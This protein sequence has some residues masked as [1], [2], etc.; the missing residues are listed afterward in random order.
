MSA[1]ANKDAVK[2]GEE[3]KIQG[4]I[5]AEREAAEAAA[6]E[7]LAQIKAVNEAL[8]QQVKMITDAA[9]KVHDETFGR[10]S[11]YWQRRM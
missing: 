11:G 9:D 1:Q 3:R 8:E 4:F 6:K 7:R 2:F 10:S 5:Q